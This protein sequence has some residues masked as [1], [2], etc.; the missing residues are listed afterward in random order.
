MKR[1]GVPRKQEKKQKN[2][3]ESAL[4]GESDV[5]FRWTVW[6]GG[7]WRTPL[8]TF[9]FFSSFP[10]RVA[11]WPWMS[12][13]TSVLH[14]TNPRNVWKVGLLPLIE[15]QLKDDQDRKN[16]QIRPAQKD[17]QVQLIDCLTRFDLDPAIEKTTTTQKNK[18]NTVIFEGSY[19]L[20]PIFL[21]K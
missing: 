11:M 10:C 14:K 9:F 21:N 1:K 20:S 13:A 6:R 5:I 16:S 19:P 17:R 8:V 18:R 7:S 4:Y 3:R 2:K 12:V 15:T